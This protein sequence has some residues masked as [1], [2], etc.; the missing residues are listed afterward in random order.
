MLGGF[1]SSMKT[2]FQMSYSSLNIDEQ[3]HVSAADH[4]AFIDVN[5]DSSE[6]PAACK[7]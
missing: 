2:I 3:S 4:K 5:E 7:D 6:A 1:S